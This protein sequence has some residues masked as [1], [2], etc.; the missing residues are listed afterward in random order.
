[1]ISSWLLLLIGSVSKDSTAIL[2]AKAQIQSALGLSTPKAIYV[3]ADLKTSDEMEASLGIEASSIGCF[4]WETLNNLYQ[5]LFAFPDIVCIVFG[6]GVPQSFVDRCTEYL[7][8]DLPHI[9][10]LQVK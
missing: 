1:M 9:K 2:W 5:P 4:S 10:Y 3:A 6:H 8:K 7:V